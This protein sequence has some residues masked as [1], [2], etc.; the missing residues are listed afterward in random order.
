MKRFFIAIICLYF[1]GCSLSKIPNPGFRIWCFIEDRKTI[2]NIPIK[3]P[4]TAAIVRGRYQ[5]PWGDPKGENNEFLE[6]VELLSTFIDIEDGRTP[7]VWYLEAVSGWEL[8]NGQGRTTEIQ[9]GGEIEMVCSDSIRLTP[10]PPPPIIGSI[11]E[12]P[13]DYGSGSGFLVTPENPGYGLGCIPSP[14]LIDILGN[15]FA[16]TDAENGVM[17]DFNGDRV[18]HQISWTAANSDDAWL[19][20]DRNNNGLIDSAL[21]M[22]GNYTAQPDSSEKNGFL[23]LAEY[24]KTS[25]GGNE[26]GSID[27]Q[28]AIFNDLRLWQDINH[29]GV[30]ETSELST[31]SSKNIAELELKYKKSKK[32]DEFGN[33]FRYRAKVWNSNKKKVGKWAWDVF[34][35]LEQP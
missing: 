33:E 15:G 9:A 24:D 30:S 26:D 4:A 27:N 34:L 10:P 20:L 35:K 2:A 7:G 25:N 6:G 29:N 14:V 11:N 22:F 32:T 5:T 23:A 1:T 13:P 3:R 21:E 17:F 8:C 19:V 18:P 28:D 12:C 31:L 16:L